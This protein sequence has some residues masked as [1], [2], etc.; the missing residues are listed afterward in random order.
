VSIE[1]KSDTEIVYV[2]GELGGMLNEHGPVMEF[3][4]SEAP[5]T[6]HVAT[7][8]SLSAPPLFSIKTTLTD[9]PRNPVPETVTDVPIDPDEG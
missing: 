8:V 5:D 6:V 3:S 4:V 7:V 9:E 1:S 2:P